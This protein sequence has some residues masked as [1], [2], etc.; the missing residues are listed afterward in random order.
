MGFFDLPSPVFSFIDSYLAIMLGSFPR[1]LIWGAIGALA[2]MLIYRLLSRQHVLSELKIQAKQLQNTINS[3]DGDFTELLPLIGQNLGLS[4]KRLWKTFIP[5]MIASLPL[6]FLVAWCSN[7]FGYDMP[8]TGDRISIRL[9]QGS[10]YYL[11]SQWVP[12]EGILLLDDMTGW[13]M[14]WPSKNRSVKLK[15]NNQTTL[16]LPP[17][18]AVPVIHKKQWWNTLIAN[19]AGYLSTDS[20][21]DIIY[22]DF[23]QHALFQF[24][25]EWLRSWWFS[26]FAALILVSLILKIRLSIH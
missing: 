18:T 13:N 24:G 16:S 17:D 5:A 6:L 12:D 25:P 1:V 21:I 2:S 15:T 19:P 22:I 11:E 10:A 23:P 7:Q 9:E 8:A 3:F 4:F 26:F 14:P 20:Q